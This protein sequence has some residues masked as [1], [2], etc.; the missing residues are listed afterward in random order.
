[1]D[2]F[3]HFR[4]RNTLFGRVHERQVSRF[5]S[6]DGCLKPANYGP[7]VSHWLNVNAERFCAKAGVHQKLNGL[8]KP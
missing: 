8:L 2:G 7:P 4:D 5:E 6:K 3:Y 1:L